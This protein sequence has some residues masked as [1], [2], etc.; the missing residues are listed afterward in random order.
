MDTVITE[1]KRLR[2][3]KEV[4]TVNERKKNIDV[5]RCSLLGETQSWLS[6][7]PPYLVCVNVG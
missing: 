2:M 5:M 6:H 3:T 7:S 4:S 1:M